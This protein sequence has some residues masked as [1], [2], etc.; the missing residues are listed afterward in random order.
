MKV[1]SERFYSVVWILTTSASGA[2][3]HHFYT[4]LDHLDADP[5]PAFRFDAD[6]DPTFH[7]DADQD[8]E[9]TFQLMRIRIRIIPLTFP[10]I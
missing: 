7:S 3:S 10:Q 4:D 6:P 5:D 8:P 2:D 1:S 9:T